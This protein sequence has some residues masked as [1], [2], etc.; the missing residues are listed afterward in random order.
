MPCRQPGF[1]PVNLVSNINNP[2]DVAAQ[3]EVRGKF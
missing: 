2:S 3:I 1:D